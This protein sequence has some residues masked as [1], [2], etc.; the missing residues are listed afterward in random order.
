MVKSTLGPLLENY[1]FTQAQ[2]DMIKG[3][4][5][6]YAI[7]GYTG[8]L[9]TEVS[10][11]SAACAANSSDSNFPECAGSSSVGPDGFPLGPSGDN[12]V[13]WLYS[14][15]NAIRQFLNV[16]TKELFPTIGDI[17]VSEFGFAEPF[18]GLD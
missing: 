12:D 11:G 18:E 9:A 4:C 8:Y 2:K 16:I 5:D 1:T 13:S 7:D 6:F 14:T 10:G 17:V 3:S 15:P